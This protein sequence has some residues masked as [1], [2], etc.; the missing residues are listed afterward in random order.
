ML[1][2]VTLSVSNCV[3]FNSDAVCF[4]F[5]ETP[6][7]KRELKKVDTCATAKLDCSLINN[8]LVN[9]LRAFRSVRE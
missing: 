3:C 2:T 8:V 1:A 4:E 5:C 9:K 6:E 7:G